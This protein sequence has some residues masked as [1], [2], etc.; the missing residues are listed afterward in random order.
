MKSKHINNC[1]LYKKIVH[2][3]FFRIFIFSLRPM[4]FIF[5]APQS[6]QVC[7]SVC[8]SVAQSPG[9]KIQKAD[10]NSILSACTPNNSELAV[11][12]HLLPF[13]IFN[14]TH[15]IP[16]QSPSVTLSADPI[17]LKSEQASAPFTRFQGYY[18]CSLYYPTTVSATYLGLVLYWCV[19]KMVCLSVARSA[20]SVSHTRKS[21]TQS[22]PAAKRSTRQ[23]SLKG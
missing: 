22:L 18:P 13:K 3:E 7:S 8:Q 5:L 19:S 11:P 4:F 14:L 1:T 20:G 9:S 17:N 21:S 6:S 16:N 10:R 15:R 23:G 2:Y 12:D